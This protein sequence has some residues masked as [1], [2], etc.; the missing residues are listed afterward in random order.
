MVPDQLSFQ[1]HPLSP[2]TLGVWATLNTANYSKLVRGFR[3]ELDTRPLSLHQVPGITFQA[4]QVV[5]LKPFHRFEGRNR[6]PQLL[7]WGSTQNTVISREILSKI[8][9]LLISTNS[10]LL[11]PQWRWLIKLVFGIY[12]EISQLTSS[13]LSITLW[14]WMKFPF[15]ILLQYITLNL[16]KCFLL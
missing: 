6:H 7:F 9:L 1:C 12:L 4:L 3:H 11:C 5:Q 2:Q 15:D 13:V 10:T 16:G 8:F 14:S